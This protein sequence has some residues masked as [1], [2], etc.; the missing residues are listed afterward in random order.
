MTTTI[1][2]LR[3]GSARRLT[4]ACFCGQFMEPNAHRYYMID[5]A[6]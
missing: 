3:F 6:P 1:Q 4:T 5:P 2:I